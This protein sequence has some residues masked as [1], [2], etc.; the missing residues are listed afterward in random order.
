MGQGSAKAR[1]HEVVQAAERGFISWNRDHEIKNKK[2]RGY[3]RE[4]RQ[5]AEDLISFSVL[6]QPVV[7]PVPFALRHDWTGM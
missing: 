6:L 3:A 1:Q 5:L 2:H 7:S 4:Q